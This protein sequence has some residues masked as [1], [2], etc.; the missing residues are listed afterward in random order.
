MSCGPSAAI[1][2]AVYR[3]SEQRYRT[4]PAGSQ[5]AAAVE[6]AREMLEGVS[7]ATSI[8][9]DGRL[10]G[11]LLPVA[12]GVLFVILVLPLRVS[13]GPWLSEPPMI[14]AKPLE[15]CSLGAYI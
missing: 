12:Y 2:Y 7:S 8:G 9:S 15:V 5:L 1:P 4:K 14:S 11:Y 6:H 10:A 3:A 13:S